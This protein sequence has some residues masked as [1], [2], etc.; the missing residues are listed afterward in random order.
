MSPGQ[1]EYWTVTGMVGA[2]S[3][4][5]AALLSETLALSEEPGSGQE[6]PGLQVGQ[7]LW[8]S[9]LP[10]RVAKWPSHGAEL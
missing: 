3:P 2:P 6:R 4:T 5:R 1:T 8:E 7:S 10:V 9:K